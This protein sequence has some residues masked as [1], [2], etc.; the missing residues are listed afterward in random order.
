MFS[1]SSYLRLVL[2]QL[3]VLKMCICSFHDLEN[4]QEKIETEKKIKILSYW[5][6]FLASSIFTCH[7]QNHICFIAELKFRWIIES[8]GNFM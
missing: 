1:V 4:F 5:R 6:N 7:L 3:Y 2:I 8:I